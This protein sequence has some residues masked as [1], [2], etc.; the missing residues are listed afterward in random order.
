LAALVPSPDWF[1]DEIS[2]LGSKD[3]AQDLRG[4]WIIELAELSAMKRGDIERTKA[5]M[6]RATDH[7]RPSYGRRSQDFPR[8][9]VF[10]GTTNADAYLSDETGNRRFW[11]VQVEKVDLEGLQRYRDLLWAEAVVA[12]KAGES[13]WLDA[14]VERAAAEEQA[15]RSS[16]DPWEAQLLPWL[17]SQLRAQKTITVKAALDILDVPRERQNQAGENRVARILKAAGLKRVQLWNGGFRRWV[18]RPLTSSRPPHQSPN[19]AS[20]DEKASSSNSLTTLTTLTTLT[21]SQETCTEAPPPNAGGGLHR[22]TGGGMPAVNSPETGEWSGATGE[23]PP[24]EPP[25][26]QQP[27]R[28]LVIPPRLKRLLQASD[29]A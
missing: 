10:A 22:D 9:C 28:V 12:Y 17:E 16:V 24:V 27:R 11:P 5:F 20:G 3:S 6:S 8:Q 26:G 29:D 23:S 2:D 4:K 18:Y 25:P 1:T 15:S 14:D 7:Y 13:W 19:D 21:S